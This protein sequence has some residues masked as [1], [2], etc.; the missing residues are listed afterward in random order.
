[1]AYEVQGQYVSANYRTG[2]S[3]NDFSYATTST[4]LKTCGCHKK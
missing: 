3:V 1:V 2:N 4:M